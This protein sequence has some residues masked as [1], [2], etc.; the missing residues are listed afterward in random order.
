MEKREIIGILLIAVVASTVVTYHIQGASEQAIE[1][2]EEK[3]PER[4]PAGEKTTHELSFS[5]VLRRSVESLI[6]D[7]DC[8][9]N[10]TAREGE[11][12]KD[13]EDAVQLI[14]GLFEAMNA[15]YTEE[16]IEVEGGTGT[17]YDFSDGFSAVAPNLSVISSTTIYS[18]IE[19][20]GR[21][22]AF[23]GVSDF[24]SNRNFSL[25]SITLSKNEVPETYLTQQAGEA[26]AQG[27]PAIMKAP[28]LG[29]K[30]YK[31]NEEDDRISARL[32]VNSIGVP[33]HNGI[34]EVLRLTVDG[35]NQRSQ[36]FFISK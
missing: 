22:Q 13:V 18:I 32:V 29:R 23:R 35:E 15:P 19:I 31:A 34:M 27:K 1:V 4:V 6:M 17:L 3:I 5:L 9:F 12:T 7:F 24:F 14:T 21:K 30:E 26:Q 36:G 20:E 8:L 28:L 16:E 33:G 11:P 10:A 25:D 2:L